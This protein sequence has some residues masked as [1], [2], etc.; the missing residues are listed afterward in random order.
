MLWPTGFAITPK[1]LVSLVM[2][3]TRYRLRISSRVNWP[4]AVP[5]SLDAAAYVHAEPVQY[6]E[7]VRYVPGVRDDLDDVA[8]RLHL[9]QPC[10]D[11]F[12]SR[13]EVVTGDD[14]RGVSLPGELVRAVPLDIDVVRAEVHR[15]LQAAKPLLLA[16]PVCPAFP[17]GT[18]GNDHRRALPRQQLRQVGLLDEIEPQLDHIG[19]ASE[20]EGPGLS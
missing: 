10:V 5:A 20:Q 13:A 15:L 4:G 3:G 18:V 9:F 7:V 11:V 6:P 14:D 1:T 2:A 16:A 12:G 8:F 17:P 19:P